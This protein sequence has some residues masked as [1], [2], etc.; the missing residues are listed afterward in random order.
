[1]ETKYLKEIGRTKIYSF[2]GHKIFTK[3]IFDT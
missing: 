3:L 2:T 1:L